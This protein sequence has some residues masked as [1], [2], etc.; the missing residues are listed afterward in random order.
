MKKKT[1][2]S[3]TK[4]ALPFLIFLNVGDALSFKKAVCSEAVQLEKLSEVKKEQTMK[5]KYGWRKLN[6]LINYSW[7]FMCD[8][9]S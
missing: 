1:I 2:T 3:V 7:T 6:E 9:L 4:P 5:T 8:Q